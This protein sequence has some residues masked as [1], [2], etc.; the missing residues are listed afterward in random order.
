M[1][2]EWLTDSTNLKP[3]FLAIALLLQNQLV[4]QSDVIRIP[5]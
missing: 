2:T 1:L 5:S 4:A 3:L